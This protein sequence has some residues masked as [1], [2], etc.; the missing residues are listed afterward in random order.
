MKL[1]Q[2]LMF[3]MHVKGK[4][5]QIVNDFIL[6]HIPWTTSQLFIDNW[7]YFDGFIE[8][9]L[10]INQP[11]LNVIYQLLLSFAKKGSI[12][13]IS[14]KILGSI[15]HLW[16]SYKMFKKTLLSAIADQYPHKNNPL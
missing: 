1:L 4:K 11:M 3:K 10:T 8:N 12:I 5:Y 15:V 16:G 9:L 2:S 6:H 7:V 14:S 13:I